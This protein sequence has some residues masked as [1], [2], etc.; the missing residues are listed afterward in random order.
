M[1]YQVHGGPPPN[2][3]QHNPSQTDTQQTDQ[4]QKNKDSDS[5]IDIYGASPPQLQ[6]L[7]QKLRDDPNEVVER[8]WQAGS[9]PGP[10]LMTGKVGGVESVPSTR[11]RVFHIL[12]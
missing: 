8:V 6:R 4:V 11:Y 7:R 12:K 3:S 10:D 5:D 1:S 2:P 9:R